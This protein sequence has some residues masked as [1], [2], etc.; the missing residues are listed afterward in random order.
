MSADELSQYEP[1]DRR[2]FIRA[3]L[4]GFLLLLTVFAFLPS[5]FGPLF[6]LFNIPAT[7]M[8]PALNLGDFAVVSLASYGY[9]KTSFDFFNLPIR[10]RWPA[11]RLPKRGDVVVFRLARDPK[12]VFVKRIVG[13]PGDK[14]QMIAGRLWIDGTVVPRD[15]A[16]TLPDPLGEKGQIPAYIEHLPG[17]PAHQI[18]EAE[19]DTGLADDTE[20]FVVPGSHYFVMGDNRDNSND[21]RFDGAKGGL[22]YVPA[23]SIIGRVVASF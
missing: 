21:S 10:G 4:F 5:N 23:E 1:S 7:S 17:S 6:R 3:G 16:G 14:V 2:V 8:A 18:L 22:G 15:P 13:L 19:G 9:S 20:L 11:S 12:T